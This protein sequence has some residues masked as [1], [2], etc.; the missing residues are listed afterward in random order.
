MSLLLPT[1]DLI[2]IIIVS[3]KADTPGDSF[4]RWFLAEITID[5]G[6]LPVISMAWFKNLTKMLQR[7]SE[8]EQW[9]VCWN[10][11]WTRFLCQSVS[12][13]MLE[14]QTVR[15]IVTQTGPVNG[16]CKWRMIMVSC[17]WN[18][19]CNCRLWELSCDLNGVSRALC[20]SN[21]HKRSWWNYNV[22]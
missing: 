4:T 1:A 20:V 6:K 10:S 13:V 19:K 16:W 18:G 5:V 15:R 7:V 12:Q 22:G 2:I 11:A 21:C 8:A 17:E 9:S 3:M 14:T